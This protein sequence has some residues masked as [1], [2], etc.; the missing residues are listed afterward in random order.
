MLKVARGKLVL[1]H[2]SL[3]LIALHWYRQLQRL[4]W[5]QTFGGLSNFVYCR[6]KT[7]KSENTFYCLSPE[8]L[9]QTAE[10][11]LQE[12][13]TWRDVGFAWFCVNTNYS[14]SATFT[15]GASTMSLA[16]NSMEIS[17]SMLR[18]VENNQQPTGSPVRNQAI[19]QH[20]SLKGTLKGK[21]KE[22]PSFLFFLIIFI[23]QG[24]V[25]SYFDLSLKIQLTL[26]WY[27]VVRNH[28]KWCLSADTENIA[29][30][31]NT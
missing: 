16:I 11:I 29:Y 2:S 7:K 22:T 5:G 9:L 24:Y 10:E 4:T 30:K 25:V 17:R 20:H 23:K 18:T 28:C 8:E 26:F 6:M 1:L 31:S 19:F 12:V 14:F 27:L 15:F 21:R 13:R 3:T